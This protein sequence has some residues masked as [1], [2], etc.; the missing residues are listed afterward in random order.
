MILEH[1]G[2][3][4][5]FWTLYGHL[6]RTSVATLEPGDPVVAGQTIARVG[7]Y[8]ENG[9]W[10]P[11]L[12]FQIMTDLLAFEGEFPGAALPRERS[13]WASF[14]P[15]RISFSGCPERRPTSSPA[16]SSSDEKAC[17]AQT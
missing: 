6:Q 16:V 3:A 14:R 11:H 10:P 15:T 1:D 5:P 7:P 17:S 12:H 13:V 8:P 4:G 2:P 9:D